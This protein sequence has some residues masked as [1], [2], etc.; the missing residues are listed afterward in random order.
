MDTEIS[1]ILFLQYQEWALTF[2]K[3]ITFLGSRE[4]YLLFIPLLYWCWDTRLGFR[5]GLILALTQ[6][7]NQSLKVAI[8]SPRP[9]WV[10]PEVKALGSELSFGM[11]SGHAQGAVCIWGIAASYTRHPWAYAPAFGISL[12]IGISRVYLGVHFPG[13]VITGWAVGVLLLVLFLMIEP[14]I[15]KRLDGLDLRGQIFASFLASFSIV[16]L[17]AAGQACMGSLPMPTLWE[18][19]ALLATGVPVDPLNSQDI[20]DAAGL[21]FG[22]CGGYALLQSL[23][24]FRAKGPAFRRLMCYLLGMAGLLLI[25]Y[26][27]GTFVQLLPASYAGYAFAYLNAILAGFWVTAGAPLLFIKMKLAERPESE[28]DRPY[29]K[30]SPG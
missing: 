6:G 16:A 8:H 14:S 10:S 5:A 28:R 4:F 26:G 20:F 1:F 19:N 21:L 17:Y 9:Y 18:A 30:T 3:L 27:R 25:W 13:D 15:A 2:M 22:I 11:P 24:G 12:L 23:G 7:L 29:L